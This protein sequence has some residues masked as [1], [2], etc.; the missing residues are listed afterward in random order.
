VTSLSSPALFADLNVDPMLTGLVLGKSDLTGLIL[1]KSDLIV[2]AL[3]T[4]L[5]VDPMLSGLVLGKS[6]VMFSPSLPLLLA[7]WVMKTEPR[8]FSTHA[9]SFQ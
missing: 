1:G 4:D 7:H 3:F 5:N 6:D 9:H 2:L 8:V